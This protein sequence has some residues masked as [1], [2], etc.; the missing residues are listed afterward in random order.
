MP[1]QQV[2]GARYPCIQNHVSRGNLFRGSNTGS[3]F[4]GARSALL[5]T[6]LVTLVLG[7]RARGI[8]LAVPAIVW[9]LVL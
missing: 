5:P 1:A 2:F 3:L 9:R 4:A 8:Q 6:M 7:A